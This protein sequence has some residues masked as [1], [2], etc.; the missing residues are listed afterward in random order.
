IKP[1]NMIIAGGPGAGK[2]TLLNALFS[3]IPADERVVVIE[4][5]LELNTDLEGNYSRLESD[6]EINLADLV[7]NSLRMRMDRVVIGEVRGSE[8]KDLMTAMNIGKYCMG[9]LHAS[10]GREAVI[11]L[12]NEPM[13]VPS[14]LINLV[15]V[16]IIMNRY[17]LNNK[18]QRVV[19]ELVETTGMEKKIVLLSPLWTCDLATLEFR[20]SQVSSVYRDKLAQASGK[21][22]KEIIEE[23]KQREELI[24]LLLDKGIR[25]I[26]EVSRIFQLFIRNRPALFAEFGFPPKTPFTSI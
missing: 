4:D 23:S 19:A 25:D 11:R 8:A 17:N 7:K 16:F 10:S 13:N 14:I 12:E 6:D 26:K 21:S 1:A 22:V 20:Q 2:S 9:T 18:I 3:F 24:Q 5:T 15:D